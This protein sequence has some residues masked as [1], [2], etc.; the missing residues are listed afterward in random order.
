MQTEPLDRTHI[1]SA[2]AI[3]AIRTWVTTARQQIASWQPDPM[4]SWWHSTTGRLR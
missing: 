1:D 2:H 4:P 3:T